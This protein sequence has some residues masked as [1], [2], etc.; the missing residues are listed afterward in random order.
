[1]IQRKGLQASRRKSRTR[2]EPTPELDHSSAG[3]RYRIVIIKDGKFV[4][5]RDSKQGRSTLA[6]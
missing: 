4:N 3:P 5:S 2:A 6:R 1:M